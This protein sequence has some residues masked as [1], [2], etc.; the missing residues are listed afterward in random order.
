MQ[1]MQVRSLGQEDPW[2]KEMAI[3]L[4]FFSEKSHGQRSLVGYGPRGHKR[5]G[6]G[7]VIKQQQQRMFYKERLQKKKMLE[8][9]ECQ[10]MRFDMYH[11]YLN[12]PGSMLVQWLGLHASTAR[13]TGLILGQGNKVPHAHDLAKTKK[14]PSHQGL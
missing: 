9:L 3:H 4:V 7:L 5:V 13:D 11:R 10:V 12:K 1:D 14:E 2:G 6:H 8:G